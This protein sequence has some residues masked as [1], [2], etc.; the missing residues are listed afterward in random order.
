MHPFLPR[1]LQAEKAVLTSNHTRILY[2]LIS[3]QNATRLLD[4]MTQKQLLVS[5]YK[6]NH[7]N[8]AAR[9]LLKHTS[10]KL[11]ARCWNTSRPVGQSIRVNIINQLSPKHRTPNHVTHES[12]STDLRRYDHFFVCVWL[13]L[14]LL[15]S[16]RLK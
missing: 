1:I 15:V 5:N 3:M 11:S 16:A 2:W 12:Q 7:S 14:L 9:F 6:K 13:F 8:N 10:A 4:Q